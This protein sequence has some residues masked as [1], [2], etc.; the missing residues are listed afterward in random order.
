[1]NKKL[2]AAA[3]GLAFAAPVFADSS[4]VTL[5]GRVHTSVVSQS[6]DIVNGGASRF[7]VEGVSSRFGIRGVE[8]LGGGLKAIFGYEQGFDSDDGDFAVNGAA[9]TA[10]ATA[11]NAYVGLDTPTFGKFSVGRLDGAISAPLYNQIFKGINHINHDGGTAQFAS[12]RADTLRGNQ[13]VSNAFGH[14][15]NVGT[16]QIDSRLSLQ[17]PGA[18]PNASINGEQGVRNFSIAA[19]TKIGGLDIGGGYERDDYTVQAAEAGAFEDRIQFVAGYQFGNLRVG[20]TLAQNTYQQ[21]QFDDETELGLSAKYKLTANSSIIGN[22]FTR[23]DAPLSAIAGQQVERDQFQVGY[24]YDFSKRTMTYV[25]FD[26]LEANSTVAQNE[27]D[28][29]IAGIRHN[30]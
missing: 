19:T 25:M 8:D 15:I 3:L 16:V 26:R 22:Y 10:S 2:V 24:T 4:N 1:M 27:R 21:A 23:D 13:R 18:A 11:R 7:D 5:Y 9:G 12:S 28:A 6:N 20:G 30:F 29:I 17:G 14:S